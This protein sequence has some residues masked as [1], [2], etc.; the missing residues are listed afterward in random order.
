[1]PLPASG[2]PRRQPPTPTAWIEYDEHVHVRR[3]D[4]LDHILAL[5]GVGPAE[6]AQWL[7]AARG[8][9]DLRR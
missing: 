9:Y 4:T 2:M 3:G 5:K 6:A 7:Y 1:M 8:V